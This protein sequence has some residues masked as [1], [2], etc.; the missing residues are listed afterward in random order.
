M[1]DVWPCYLGKPLIIH[2]LQEEHDAEL[3]KRI[4]KQRKRAV[5]AARGGRKSL[6]SRNS[7]KDKGGKSSHNSKI[8]KQL[9]SW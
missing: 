3:T 1:L 6:S 9:N 8:Q 7:Y 5:V 4:E 2:S